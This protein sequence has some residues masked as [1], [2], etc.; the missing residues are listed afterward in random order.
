MRH[1]GLVTLY[2]SYRFGLFELLK[3]C[4][5][6]RICLFCVK[7]KIDTPKHVITYNVS[8]QSLL[9][10]PPKNNKSQFRD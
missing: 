9:S 3:K 5:L 6:T 10:E 7:T 1:F 2:L 8:V 4:I